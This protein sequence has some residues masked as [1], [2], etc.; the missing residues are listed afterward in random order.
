MHQSSHFLRGSLADHVGPWLLVGLLLCASVIALGKPKIALAGGPEE[1]RAEAVSSISQDL[2]FPASKSV[3]MTW[4]VTQGYN[5]SYTHGTGGSKPIANEQYAFDLVRAETGQTTDKME[6]VS[7]V[8]GTIVWKDS[9]LGLVMVRL[10][11]AYTH[12]KTKSFL[13][14]KL[15][16]L[17]GDVFERLKGGDSV[18]A[19]Q[20]LGQTGEGVGGYIA[21]IHFNLFSDDSSAGGN[22][23]G[24]VPEWCRTCPAQ[25]IS[26]TRQAR[27]DQWPN[28]GS[29]NEY[30]RW[31][32]Q[33]LSTIVN[34]PPS[35]RFSIRSVG[36]TTP[37][38]YTGQSITFDGSGSSDP[39]GSITQW[40]WDFGDGSPLVTASSTATHIFSAAKTYTVRLTVTDD[41]GAKN[42]SEPQTIRILSPG[43]MAQQNTIVALVIDCT[44]SMLDSD[45][46][47]LRKQAAKVYIQLAQTGDRIA[48][49]G[50]T[51]TSEVF[52]AL[53]T[54]RTQ[55]DRDALQQAVDRIYSSGS[56]D[57]GTGLQAGYDA[58]S[59]D[60][61]TNPRRAAVFLTDG[62]QDCGSGCDYRDQHL[63]YRNRGWRVYT[64]GLG[65]GQDVDLLR[66]IAAETGARYY[67]SPASTNLQAIYRDLSGQITGQTSLLHDLF[68]LIQGASRVVTQSIPRLPDLTVSILWEGAAAGK[69]VTI[70][71]ADGQLKILQAS[72][73]KL[74]LIDPSGRQLDPNDASIE[75]RKGSTFELYRLR[76]PQP[77]IWTY[78]IEAITASSAVPVALDASSLDVTAPIGRIR[79]DKPYVGSP[80]IDLAFDVLDPDH[81]NDAEIEYR[82]SNDGATWSDWQPIAGGA[83]WTLA[84]PND[85]VYVYSQFRD[86]AGNT[87]PIDIA[88]FLVDTEPPETS[89]TSGP[90]GAVGSQPV[91]FEWQGT[92]NIAEGEAEYDYSYKLDG[93]DA[94]WSA[95]TQGLR[96][97]TYSLL[98]A[99]TYTFLVRARDYAGNVDPTP[100]QRTF[101]IAGGGS[102]QMLFSSG[103]GGNPLD[104][105]VMNEDGTD[106]RRLTDIDGFSHTGRVSPNGEQIVFSSILTGESQ[107]HA[108][109]MGSAGSSVRQLTTDCAT[110]SEAAW[111]PDGSRIVFTCDYALA[112]IDPDGSQLLKTQISGAQPVWSPL[113]NK[114][115]FTRWMGTS[116]DWE[117]FSVDVDGSHEL[118]LTNS[119][120][121][122][123]LPAWSPDG[124]RIAFTHDD[125]DAT[126]IYVMNADGTGRARVSAVP[127]GSPAWSP[128]GQQIAFTSNRDGNT[129]L[130]AMHLDGSNLR[131]LTNWPGRDESPFWFASQQGATS[132]T[133]ITGS[134]YFTTYFGN[135][136]LNG[137]SV[138]PGDV[139]EAF[140]PRGDRVGCFQATSNSVYGYMRVYGEDATANPPT[141][142]M[143]TNEEVTF[144]ING[145]PARPSTCP[146]RWTDDKT[147]HSL[148][149]TGPGEC[150]REQKLTLHRGWNWISLNRHPSTTSIASVLTSIGGKYDLVLGE[151]GTFAPPPADPRFN[152]LQQVSDGR[153][154]MLRMNQDAT[155]TVTGDAISVSTPIQLGRGWRWLGYL[156]ENGRDIA[157]ALSS[158]SGKFS[159][160]LG[161]AGTYAPPPADPRFNT[162]QTMAPGAGYMIRMIQDA[163]L[164]YPAT[165]S[166][167][168]TEPSE[169]AKQGEGASKAPGCDVAST[170]YFTQVYGEVNVD[171]QPAPVGTRV[172]ALS[173]RGD[174]VGC[175]QVTSVGV[176]GYMR[177]FGEDASSTP[178]TPG[179]RPGE[180]MQFKVDGQA[181][182]ANGDVTWQDDKTPRVI[183]LNLTQTTSSPTPTP[184]L[185]NTATPSLTPTPFATITP[186]PTFTPTVT[187][188]ATATP[189]ASVT[190]QLTSTPTAT[191]TRAPV[192]GDYVDYLPLLIRGEQLDPRMT[193]PNRALGRTTAASSTYN[194]DYQPARAVD[195]AMTTRWSS[196]FS[197][198]EWLTVD[199]GDIYDLR[200]MR[201]YW[202]KAYATAYR[203]EA[204]YDGETWYPVYQESQGDGGLDVISMRA[205]GRFV[206]LVGLQ[207]ATPWGYSLWEWEIYGPMSA[208]TPTPT[209]PTATPSPL[210]CTVSGPS[211]Y[212]FA[213]LGET[214]EYQDA[215]PLVGEQHWQGTRTYLNSG[216]VYSIDAKVF[217]STGH[218]GSRCDLYLQAAGGR[219][220]RTTEHC[221]ATC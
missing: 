88:N 73:L 192:I 13:F 105:Y 113:G 195:G 185:I 168:A 104:L 66:R 103:R 131:R 200:E 45:P 71:Q 58:L 21:H 96:S 85:A 176:Y 188:T 37:W 59:S 35:A 206:R 44:G 111:S 171:S 162:L 159:L 179:M 120:G 148:D 6:V 139:I 204:S 82:L 184:T 169:Q 16:H 15:G 124:R 17:R 29:G 36:T 154:Y 203:I 214:G 143:R 63:L 102:R 123:W 210:M 43:S 221:H 136:T 56:T 133:G 40:A 101:A 100:A 12:P 196:A 23:S 118:R 194:W 164:V 172:E 18:E 31:V 20:L 81:P 110:S 209:P 76:D 92:D 215:I 8:K 112:F 125:G 151:E 182:Q 65:T 121:L 141:P 187:P 79:N 158:V 84:S 142:G 5:G 62:Y 201:L 80:D 64:V 55:A 138:A 98:P 54:I 24:R 42:P 1:M 199:L 38:A 167:E 22:G 75:H 155:L 89:I 127:G 207:R 39:D 108:F 83:P 114:V 220:G 67:D 149:L 216:N 30:G 145:T 52:A 46:A 137:R 41:S 86:S 166:K 26:P 10:D 28:D 11:A 70:K 186:T 150:P 47:N 146:V 217:C 190:P 9:S 173:P 163:A 197:D 49:I 77:G 189:S 68:D 51:T 144:K 152:T 34:R 160:L 156:P 153:G 193:E 202:E 219:Y 19:N 95:F 60:T 74:T 48:V 117:L 72:D 205:S 218:Y 126:R 25:V 94:D 211:S 175:F 130:Y 181:A 90:S 180:V 53:R 27:K 134:P 198:S 115:V 147:P 129:E 122:D 140:N 177:A 57:L 157:Y 61:S 208:A 213:V 178:L 78:R 7:P 191:S 32:I 132:C 87:S 2:V 135:A 4:S 97:T 99:G 212:Q 91:A 165:S 128:D 161:E 170:P 3:T 109:I 50:F 107:Y 106:I 174:L 14:A 116:G 33:R 69:P 93:Y 119:A 183:N